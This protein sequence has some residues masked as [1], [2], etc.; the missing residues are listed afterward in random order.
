M[1]L[2]PFT[3][4]TTAQPKAQLHGNRP[5]LRGRERR[6]CSPRQQGTLFSCGES[7]VM[8]QDSRALTAAFSAMSQADKDRLT[9]SERQMPSLIARGL[10]LGI[11]P[12][13]ARRKSLQAILAIASCVRVGV[14]VEDQKVVC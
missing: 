5:K 10:I 7:F 13:F 9:L 11:T 12:T 8:I 14:T 6:L 4:D 1:T 3:S 2:L